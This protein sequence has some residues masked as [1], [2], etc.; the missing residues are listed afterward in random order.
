MKMKRRILVI[1]D[2][3]KNIQVA[4][5]VLDRAGY[6]CEYALDG[7]SGL[8]WL[9][10]EPFDLVL[11]DVMM[12]GEDGF[13]ICRLIKSNRSLQNIPVIFLTAKTDRDS[14]I[15]GFESGGSDYITKPFD[16]KELEIRV[17]N[18]IELKVNRELLEEM[19]ENLARVVEQKTTNLKD[20]N[21]K[22]EETIAELTTRNEE[23][24]R[25][26]VSRQ[27]FMD[28]LGNEVSGSLN[29][30]TGMLQVIK[31][32]VDSR[33][34]A[35]LIDRVD[36]ALSKIEVFVNAGLRVTELQ[37]KVSLLKP[38]RVD[39]NKLIGYAMFHLDEKIRR[40]Q[41]AINNQT[42]NL[43]SFITGESQ[44]LMAA[45]IMILD[46]FLER[47]LPNTMLTIEISYEKQGVI[48]E[49]TDQGQQVSEG[50]IVSFFD[51]SF[52][53]VQSLNF[54]RGIA[55]AHHGNISVNNRRDARGI[56]VRMTLYT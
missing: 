27:Q 8:T 42:N 16:A 46:F 33:K 50:E 44:L 3:P 19:N 31:Y 10:T 53:G 18:H 45:F 4:A 2:N 39:L 24:K 29:E 17:K 9:E 6:A 28:M 38:E 32:K 49:F 13:E 7:S 1:D 22:L 21:R 14:M 5:S 35:G 36:N 52:P 34:V 55:E 20:V 43:P 37:S 56:E 47:N 26:E 11:L 54:S 48:I 23:L 25:L 40:K 12:P 51:A 41:I 15:Q 30:I